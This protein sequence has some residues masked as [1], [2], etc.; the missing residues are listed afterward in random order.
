MERLAG[1]SQIWRA[2][3]GRSKGE[4][5]ENARPDT[6]RG[7]RSPT[8]ADR[9]EA[10]SYSESVGEVCGAVAVRSRYLVKQ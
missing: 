9:R 4:A 2:L 5:P 8:T 10:E 6:V 1:D 3:V 7:T